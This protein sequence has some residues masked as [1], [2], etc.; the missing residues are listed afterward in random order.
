MSDEEVRHAEI[1]APIAE[2]GAGPSD[3][4][5]VQSEQAEQP[6]VP[7]RAIPWVAVPQY[8]P[9]DW[10]VDPV[11]HMIVTMFISPT[12][13]FV[14]FW[15]PQPLKRFAVR[16]IEV[17]KQ[18]EQVVTRPSGLVVPGPGAKIQ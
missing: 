9:V 2:A 14:A 11:Q 18:V 5:E 10:Q 16:A 4:H 6:Q 7:M 1:E 15:E 3:D 17:A 12:G 13:Q 8:V